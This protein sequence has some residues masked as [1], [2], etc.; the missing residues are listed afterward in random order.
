MLCY[1]KASL[2]KNSKPTILPLK[3]DRSLKLL[4]DDEFA[5]FLYCKLQLLAMNPPLR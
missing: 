3:E 1:D 2:V 5:G 4:T